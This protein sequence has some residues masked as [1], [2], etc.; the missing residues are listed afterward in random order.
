MNAEHV[1]EDQPIATPGLLPPADATELF[2]WESH[3]D[4]LATREFVGAVRE[5]AGFTVRV[6]GVQRENGT[7]TRRI[8][9]EQTGIRSGLLET[10][11]ARQLA[12]AI[13]SS[14]YEIDHTTGG[15]N[16]G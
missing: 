15:P 12:A 10:E 5:A 2:A 1:T 7:C 4:G 6:E 9:I 16:R 3:D 14:A 11:A 8:S 13:A